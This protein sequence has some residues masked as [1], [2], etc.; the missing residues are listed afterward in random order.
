MGREDKGQMSVA[1]SILLA[2]AALTLV[3]AGMRASRGLVVPFLLAVFI[4]ILCL[5]I[6]AWL[7]RRDV[8]KVLAVL[9]IV[10]PFLVI[11]SVLAIVV[12]IS[13]SDF[14]RGLPDYQSR[15]DTEILA[16]VDF[17]RSKNINVSAPGLLVY[18]DLSKISRATERAVSGVA[19]LLSNG[20]LIFFTV[21]FMLIEASHVPRKFRA[22]GRDPARALAVFQK[23]SRTAQRYLLIKA[24]TG[25]A[26]GLAI[27]LWV[28]VL[29]VG[30]PVLWG[31][32]AFLLN[33]V[34]YVGGTFATAPPVL[35]ALAQL[36]LAPA[37]LT[38]LGCM[39]VNTTIALVEPMLL[40][41]KSGEGLSPLVVFLS[42]VLW[43]WVLGPVGA[44][45]SVP[46]T[47]IVK[48]GLESRE[49]CRWI[50]VMLGSAHT[51]ELT[52]DTVTVPEALAQ[53]RM[54]G[55]IYNEAPL[56][57]GVMV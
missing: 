7:R 11:G 8:P 25:V 51:R 42:L 6:L 27:G 36:G 15:V 28:A 41:G 30:Y 45:L 38:A 20:L 53:V 47:T 35:L 2:M 18:F 5:P 17:L 32:L 56:D 46:L 23:F 43:G 52:N 9:L 55:E 37:I 31:L 12:G 50:A 49:E 29:G 48:I 19:S 1:M 4:S 16:L 14:A 39:F 26:T 54:K 34:P 24:L 57:R 44:I 10:V 22:A 40:A 3:L 21:V 33:F 13:V